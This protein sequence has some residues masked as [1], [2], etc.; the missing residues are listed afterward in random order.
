MYVCVYFRYIH[1]AA[2]HLICKVSTIAEL[3]QH[4]GLSTVCQKVHTLTSLGLSLQSYKSIVVLFCPFISYSTK[5]PINFDLSFDLNEFSADLLHAIKN[6][7][8]DIFRC[9]I[10]SLQVFT[11]MIKWEVS[12]V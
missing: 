3:N 1:D 9:T 8:Y 10:I 4:L 5:I 11:L 2:Y 12:Y 7:M 6:F